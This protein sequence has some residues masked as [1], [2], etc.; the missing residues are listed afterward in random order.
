MHQSEEPSTIK[1]IGQKIVDKLGID[2]KDKSVEQRMTDEFST[3][4]SDKSL[5]QAIKDTVGS[6][7]STGE[8]AHRKT[9]AA[10]GAIND[11]AAKL[12]G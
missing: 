1:K 9:I 5:S 8:I 6:N 3:K 7:P 10:E 4:T 11:A 2:P 12:K